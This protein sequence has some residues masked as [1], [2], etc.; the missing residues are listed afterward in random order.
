[1]HRLELGIIRF[2]DRH[3]E[4]EEEEEDARRRQM[5]VARL[6]QKFAFV[7]SPICSPL[8]LHADSNHPSRVAQHVES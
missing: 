3:Q 8:S 5:P 1:M 4:E 2:T 7:S 6:V